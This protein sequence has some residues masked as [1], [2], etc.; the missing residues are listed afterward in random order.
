MLE[1]LADLRERLDGRLVRSG[2]GRP[3]AE[4]PALARSVGAS[5]VHFSAD[6]G[7]VRAAADRAPVEGGSAL[8]GHPGLHCGRRPVLGADPGRRAVHGIRAR[9]TASGSAAPRRADRAPRQLG[10][11][12]SRRASGPAAVA[13]LAGAAS[14]R[15]RTR[16]R[17]RRGGAQ[18]L[19]RPSCAQTCATIADNHDALGARHDVATVAVPA[20]RLPLAARGRERARRAARAPR[21]PAPALLARLLPPRAAPLPAQRELGVPGA[22]P[23]DD[24]VEPRAAA[25]RGVVARA[26]PATRWSTPACASCGARGGCTTARAWWSARS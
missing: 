10:S 22:L 11:L 12:P 6:V 7:P 1:C 16:P 20:L 15:W 24:R 26:A 19:E 13:G 8:V 18:A 21:L 9:F 23:R 5:E 14:R 17:R 25:L 3:S 2:A 4:L